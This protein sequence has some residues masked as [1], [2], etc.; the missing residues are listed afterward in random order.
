MASSY[1][2]PPVTA[3]KLSGIALRTLVGAL[4][5]GSMGNMLAKKLTADSGIDRFRRASAGDA[6]TI[7]VPLPR[8]ASAPTAPPVPAVLAKVASGATSVADGATLETAGR[9]QEAYRSG[10]SDPVRVLERLQEHIARIDEGS[11]RMG[12]FIAKTPAQAMQQA[13]ASAE[14]WRRGQPLS[15]LDGVP[16]VV[17]DELD[18]EGL[19]TTLGTRFLN[20]PA[21]RDAT[22]VAR[23]KAAG[24][25]LLG[26]AN[27]NEIG[28]N[29][30][31]LNPHHGACRNPY[32]R[33][34]ITGGSSSGSAAVVAAGLCPVSIG[35]DGGG[36][37]RIPASLCGV[38]G[39]KATFGRISEAGVPPL[40]WTPGHVGPIGLTVA[41]VA[42][43]YALVAGRDDA[44]PATLGQSPVHLSGFADR[45]LDGVRL[46]ICRPYFD[47][48]DP[49]VVARC[50]E[51][52][53][54]LTAAGAKVV[55]IPPPDL[56]L[57]L[58]SHTIIIL[59]EMS[60]AMLVHTR[61]DSSRFGYDTRIN[62]A[63]GRWFSSNDL[64][65]AMRHRHAITREYLERMRDVDVIV[66]PTTATVAPL[67][68][69]KTLP[70][71]ESNLPLVDALM[72]FVRIGNLTGFPVLSLPAGYDPQ[73][74]PVGVQLMARPY[75]EHLLFR[76]GRV[77]EAAVPRRTPSVHVRALE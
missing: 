32:D 57:V 13:Q 36:S 68:S 22:V 34:R 8:D 26:K 75:E 73:G 76:L 70:D 46:G 35:A 37:I 67:I 19:P 5:S 25:V 59:S 6:S 39:L 24:A 58:W 38:V 20:A 1:E 61:E 7:Q 9:F 3:P 14:R 72:R 62:L 77:V 55:E 31:G 27:M 28:I 2:R 52:V 44:D 65:H 21:A 12:L 63:L 43:A 64:V 41:D 74:M 66:T 40:C 48:A 33:A 4:E 56:N 18:W 16:V 17:K 51:A 50:N 49:E 54:T 10:K 29:P 71:G 45:S 69:E 11:S 60:T 15:P 30:I 53:A 42:T 23:L 47:D